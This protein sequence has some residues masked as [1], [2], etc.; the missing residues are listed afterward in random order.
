MPLKAL[1]LLHLSTM[2]CSFR[3]PATLSRIH[4]TCFSTL[5]NTVGLSSWA[6][7]VPKVT[8]PRRWKAGGGSL[9]PPLD[10]PEEEGGLV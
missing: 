5:V 3:W 1:E 9:P 10:L 2:P 4:P 6:Q 7:E 8:R